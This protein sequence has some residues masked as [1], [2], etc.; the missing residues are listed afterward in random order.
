MDSV[1]ITVRIPK[2]MREELRRYKVNVSEV[3]RR[4]LEEEIRR[5]RLEEL[6]G[7]AEELGKFFARIPEE[8][9]VKSIREDRD[10]R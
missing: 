4:A 2:A 3:A 1:T 5:R 8:R 10:T 7:Y 9:I 6:E